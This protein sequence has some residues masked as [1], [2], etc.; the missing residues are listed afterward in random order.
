MPNLSKLITGAPLSDTIITAVARLVDDA[1]AGTREPSHSDI[2]FCIN[3]AHLQE[4]DPKVQ[5]QPVGKAKRVRN[6]LYWT[7][8]NAP[9][10]GEFFVASLVSLVRGCGGFRP[11]S[12]NYVGSDCI[13]SAIDAFRPEGYELTLDGELR[14]M[15]LDNLSGTALTEALESYIRRARRGVMD[16]AL[17]TGT[18]KDLLEATAAHILQELWGTY[19]ERNNFPTLL[20][21]AFVAVGLATS[22]DKPQPGE[23]PQKRMERVMY[24]LGL[25]IN[26]LRNKEGTGHGRPWLPSVSD[27]EARI[28]TELM[29]SIAELLLLTYK[30]K[31]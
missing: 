11:E 29:S 20:G 24:D 10:K 9:E 27:A 4:C 17:V 7:M 25:A 12:P 21:Q 8:D 22:Q 5:G 2:E 6:V 19:S 15:I 14:P 3:R 30:N 13:K 16:A 26:H 1:Q 28:A 31:K 23:A 18:G